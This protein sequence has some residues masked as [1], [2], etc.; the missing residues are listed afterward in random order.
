M[1]GEGFDAVAWLRSEQEFFATFPRESAKFKAAA[2]ELERLL[3]RCDVL[4]GRPFTIE[5]QNL[6]AE[7]DALRELLAKA[8]KEML[9][10]DG[11][12][13]C[14]HSVGICWCSWIDLREDMRSALSALPGEK[15]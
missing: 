10:I 4:S 7:R 15:G 11:D 12:A 8:D 6:K 13:Y 9:L 2:D 3:A 5:A 14:D 1:S